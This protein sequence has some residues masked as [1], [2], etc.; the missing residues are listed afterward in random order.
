MMNLHDDLPGITLRS[1][2]YHNAPFKSSTRSVSTGILSVKNI[3]HTR[4]QLAVAERGHRSRIVVAWEWKRLTECP[5][6]HYPRV[7][8]T[9]Y[10]IPSGT[11]AYSTFHQLTIRVCTGLFEPLE[12][13]AAKGKSSVGFGPFS[14]S[15]SNGPSFPLSSSFNL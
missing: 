2:I 5:S 9:S 7:R 13:R 10:C 4:T 11:V 8:I 6:L 15:D 3:H 1:R 14:L 12:S